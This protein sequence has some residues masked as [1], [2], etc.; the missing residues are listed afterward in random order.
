MVADAAHS[1][2]ALEVTGAIPAGAVLL[3]TEE[4]A[5]EVTP[6]TETA[7]ARAL[8]EEALAELTATGAQRHLVT[9]VRA[10]PRASARDLVATVA[11][12]VCRG[13]LLAIAAQATIQDTAE[14]TTE[15]STDVYQ[16]EIRIFDLDNQPSDD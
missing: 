6:V 9:A 15:A 8:T 5:G 3:L 10:L 12:Q 11:A 4:L 7:P 1:N 14:R 13:G 16:C 2:A